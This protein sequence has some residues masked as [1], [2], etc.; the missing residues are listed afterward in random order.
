MKGP[1]LLQ[2]FETSGYFLCPERKKK[3][4]QNLSIPDHWSLTIEDFLC[5]E[6]RKTSPESVDPQPSIIEDRRFSL[7][8]IQPFTKHVDPRPST[9]DDFCW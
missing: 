9:V 2:S 6:K 5:P 8:D 4:H 3:L 7:V 1:D